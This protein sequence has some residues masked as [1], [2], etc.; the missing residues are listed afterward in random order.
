MRRRRNSKSPPKTSPRSGCRTG[1]P[2]CERAHASRQAREAS[3]PRGGGERPEPNLR[4]EPGG[5]EPG[6]ALNGAYLLVVVVL[7]LAS[8]CPFSCAPP[9]KKRRTRRGP[10]SNGTAL[11]SSQ[12]ER[13]GGGREGGH[14]KGSGRCGPSCPSPPPAV[15]RG[16]LRDAPRGA[17]PP[18]GVTTTGAVAASSKKRRS[19]DAS[20]GSR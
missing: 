17:L 13:A 6:L 1:R 16:R 19:L 2:G 9:A 14:E 5:R 3:W 15:G 8:F 10:K 11:R 7:F 12:E 4:L 18:G 20:S